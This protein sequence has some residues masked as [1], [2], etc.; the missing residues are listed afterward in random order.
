[1]LTVSAVFANGRLLVPGES[2]TLPDKAIVTQQPNGPLK[3]QWVRSA[4]LGTAEHLT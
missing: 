4:C 2:V 1:M 3:G